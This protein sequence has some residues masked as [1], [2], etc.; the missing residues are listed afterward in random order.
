MKTV[1][2]MK[3]VSFQKLMMTTLLGLS[4]V[5]TACSKSASFSLMSDSAK[6]GD[7][8]SSSSGLTGFVM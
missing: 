5:S 2:G 6:G 4:L 3:Q 8:G 1:R 7:I